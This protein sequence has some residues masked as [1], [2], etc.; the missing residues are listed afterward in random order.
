METIQS[1]IAFLPSPGMGHLIPLTEFAK[2]LV[3]HHNFLVT[4]ILPSDGS[5]MSAQKSYLQSLPATITPIYLPSVSF[6]DLPEDTRVE[7]RIA[8]TIS[9]SLPAIHDALF[10]LLITKPC[11]RPISALVVDLFGSNAFRLARDLNMSSYMFFT[12]TAMSFSLLVHL[13]KLD[14]TYTCEY[15][16]LTEAVV[17]PG[18]VPLLGKD[19]LDAIQERKNDAYNLLLELCKEYGSADGILI[20]SFVELEFGALKALKEEGW[21]K[22]PI[23]PVGPLIQTRSINEV[24]PESSG[25]LE[26]L[27]NQ[28]TKSVLFVCLGSGGTLSQEQ[29]N[30]MAFGLEMSEQR[31]LWIVRSPHQT[32]A[33][34]AFFTNK[35]VNNPLNFVPKGFLKRTK[36]KGLVVPSWAPQIQVLSH[37]STG[38]FVSHCGWNSVLE[39]IVHGVPLIAWPLYA[40]QKMNAVVLTED[41]KAALKVKADKIGLVGREQIA[42]LAKDLI[43]GDEGKDVRDKMKQLK[44]AAARAFELDGSSSI[45]L[46]QVAQK[47]SVLKSK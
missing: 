11:S 47:M 23:Y 43:Q 15:R 34:A 25:C 46:A 40:E 1:H 26:W 9:R 31:F 2:R 21:F 44:D 16:D 38:G 39:S 13:P 12:S 14:Q 29:I 8:L 22:P 7:T 20:N 18:C 4:L 35:S 27:N 45:S 3:L 32:A 41:L 37:G 17:L 30:E 10:Q 6:D 24:V 33:N 19:F 36:E 28:P 5:P 42:K